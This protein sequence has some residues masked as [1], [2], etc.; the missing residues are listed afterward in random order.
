M[1]DDF[2]DDDLLLLQELLPAID[3][4]A[5]RARIADILWLRLRPRRA[6][7]A[8]IALEAYTQGGLDSGSWNRGQSDGWRRALTLA[9]QL[10]AGDE[11]ERIASEVEGALL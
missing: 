2:S 4:R 3:E 7:L 8:R 11:I 9:L 6:D 5:L 1:P 10:R